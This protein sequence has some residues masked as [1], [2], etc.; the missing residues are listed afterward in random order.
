MTSPQV[1]STDTRNATFSQALAAGVTH[2]GWLASKTPGPSGRALALASHSVPLERLEERLTRD[3]SGPLFAGSSPSADLQRC[4]ESRLRAKMEGLGSVEYALTWKTWDIGSVP[5]ICARRA[6]TRRTSDNAC[7]GWGTPK[8]QQGKYQYGNGDH[9]KICLNLEGQAELARWATP[10]AADAASAG[11]RHSRGVADTL[12]AQSRIAGWPTASSRDWKDAPG[13]ATQAT[14]P[15]GTTRTRLDQLPR[16]ARLS[17]WPTPQEDNAN[18]SMGHKGTAYSDLPTTAQLTGP[19]LSTG[20]APMASIEGC[21]PDGWNPPASG[22]LNPAFSLWLMGYPAEWASC[23]AQAM[24][25]CRQSRRRS[26][27]RV[28]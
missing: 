18:N 27:K 3:T 23:G 20:P 11:T 14:N 9:D 13:M 8:V 19:T 24:Q 17:G 25:S 16:V 10:R 12:T 5:P 28:E 21:L 26:S 15:D 1:T 7:S 6:S 4:L 22:K 2:S